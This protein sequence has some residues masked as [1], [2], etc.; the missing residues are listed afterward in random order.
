MLGISNVKYKNVTFGV[1]QKPLFPLIFSLFSLLF[2]CN[3]ESVSD[4]LQNAGDI[5]RKEIIAP[6]FTKI[7]VFENQAVSFDHCAYF[8]Q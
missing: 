5:V 6:D 4:C 7:T 8:I 1:A 3:K 2:S